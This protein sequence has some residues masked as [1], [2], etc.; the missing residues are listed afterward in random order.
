MTSESVTVGKERRRGKK[1]FLYNHQE[2]T[3]EPRDFPFHLVTIRSI[4]P[5][6][7]TTSEGN[8]VNP[9]GLQF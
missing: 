7:I 4:T 1:H 5:G 6:L 3:E 2:V 9:E 8:T